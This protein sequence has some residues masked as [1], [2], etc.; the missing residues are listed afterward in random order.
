[1]IS[2]P[3]NPPAPARE[4]VSKYSAWAAKLGETI[5]SI[6]RRRR[7]TFALFLSVLGLSLAVLPE[8]GR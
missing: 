1:M 8:R 5:A 7:V 3:S 2:V 4:L 6:A